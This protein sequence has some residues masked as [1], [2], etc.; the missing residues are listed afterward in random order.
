MRGASACVVKGSCQSQLR[1]RLAVVPSSVAMFSTV[2]E[3]VAMCVC[4]CVFLLSMT[5]GVQPVVGCVEKIAVCVESPPHAFVL[6]LWV[7]CA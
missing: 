2:V 5:L 6:Q 1:Y 4:V 3:S 7:F